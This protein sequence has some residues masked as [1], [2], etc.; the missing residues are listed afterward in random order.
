VTRTNIYVLIACAFLGILLYVVL[1]I[2]DQAQSPA[3][4]EIETAPGADE[5]STPA[6]A[7][8]NLPK[9]R[10]H[11]DLLAILSAAEVN[12]NSV[13]PASRLW[14]Q[15][16]GF[17]GSDELLGVGTSEA[18]VFFYQSLDGPTL[19]AM[20]QKGDLGALQALAAENLLIDPFLATDFYSQAA[21]EGSDYAMLQIASLL[22]TFSSVSPADYDADSDYARKLARFR[23]S[24]GARE[25]QENAF[26]FALAALRGSGAPVAQPDVLSWIQR[27]AANFTGEA[28]NEAC[29]LSARIFFEMSAIR[30]SR[31]KLRLSSQPPPVF[32]SAPD[33]AQQMPCGGTTAP[34][35]RVLDTADCWIRRVEDAR[36]RVLNLHVCE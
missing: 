30:R 32:F 26:A 15:E 4:A 31:G 34:V 20:S 35:D 22:E 12:P 2:V 24:R 27:L 1:G 11:A 36:G 19:E 18:P 10:T 23:A 25:L 14:L 21:A 7:A 9:L 6:A 13:L 17:L 33:L 28:L 5:L 16:R 3:P 8:T 29:Q